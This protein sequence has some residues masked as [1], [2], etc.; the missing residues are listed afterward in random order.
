M[1][2]EEYIGKRVLIKQLWSPVDEYKVLEIS[3]N[4][5]YVKLRHRNGFEGWYSIHEIDFVDELS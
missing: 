5:K 3:K 1:N 2:W 4:K